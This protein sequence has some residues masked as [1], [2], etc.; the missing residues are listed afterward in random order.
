[1]YWWTIDYE[2]LFSH[3]IKELQFNNYFDYYL[4]KHFK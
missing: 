2:T 1:M 4:R 3:K